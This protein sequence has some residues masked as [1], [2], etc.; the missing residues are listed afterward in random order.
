MAIFTP[1]AIISE[2]RG[3]IANVTYSRSRAGAISK[4]KLIQTN[5]NSPAQ[6]AIRALQAQAVAA[7]QTLPQVD[8]DLW[9]AFSA[10]QLS[11]ARI[12]G[13]HKLSGYNA[14]IRFFIVRNQYGLAGNP[15]PAAQLPLGSYSSMSFTASPTSLIFNITGNNTNPDIILVFRLTDGLSPGISS[16]NQSLLI[17]VSEQQAPNGTIAVNLVAQWVARYGPIG[18]ASGKKIFARMDIVNR[19]TAQRSVIFRGSTFIIAP[20]LLVAVSSTGI[21]NRV[22][23]SPDGIAWTT[24]I[25]AAD[26]NWQSVAWS[27][28]LGLFA[29]VANSGPVVRCMTSPDGIA[30]TIR[31]LNSA[32]NWESI[33]WAPGISLFIAVASSGAGN[34]VVTSPDGVIWTVRVSAAD[35]NWQSI[36][37]SPSLNLLAA[38]SNSGS[39]NRVMTSPDGIAWTSR[40]SAVDNNWLSVAWSPELSLFCAVS[41]TGAGN[42]V[43]SSPDGTNWTIR[44]SATDK[45]WNSI[46]WS[47]TLNLFIAVASSGAIDRVMT[48][49]D[50]IAWTSQNAASA[51]EWRSVIWSPSLNIL[52]AVGSAG[53]LDRIMTSPDGIVWQLQIAATTNNWQSIAVS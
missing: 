14:F 16:V 17:I 52:I 9:I 24:R 30:W 13:S 2:I 43:M 22:M 18:A 33:V 23:T 50:G 6:I 4:Q 1:G 34:R 26:F 12:D 10:S 11:R 7:W 32:D 46:T 48:S 20:S 8:Q 45:S 3:S 41:S 36:A 19:L 28:S 5:P 47:P 39:G 15:T 27:P 44:I 42:R 31:T 29:A 35:N 49:P 53:G 25:S 51:N 37:W 38:V 40:L 21:G